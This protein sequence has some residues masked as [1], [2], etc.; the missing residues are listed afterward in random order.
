MKR[1]LTTETKMDSNRRSLV[2]R[3]W[4][5]DDFELARP[6]GK[7]QFGQVYLMRER[8]SGFVVAMKVIHKADLMKANMEHQLRREIDIQSNLK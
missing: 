6:L 1:P 5:L 4:C 8:Q 2:T 7:G 3:E